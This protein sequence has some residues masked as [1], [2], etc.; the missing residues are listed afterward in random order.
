MTKPGQILKS[1]HLVNPQI[2]ELEY[3]DSEISDCHGV[4]DM[5]KSLDKVA[6]GRIL[7][8]LLVF[9]EHTEI[10]KSVRN[11]IVKENMR[12]R[13]NISAEAIVVHSFAQKL[14]MLFYTI[15]LKNIYP[16]KLFTDKE[17]ATEWLEQLKTSG[18]A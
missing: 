14:S 12:R 11:L 18:P 16:V 6:H 8:R 15:F 17:E 7:K 9:N 4:K 2:V 13:N 3:V 5:N 1:V 10:S